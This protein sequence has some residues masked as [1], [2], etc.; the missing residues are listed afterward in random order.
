[1]EKEE[2]QSHPEVSSCENTIGLSRII[3]R[4]LIKTL[5]NEHGVM[6]QAK[7]PTVLSLRKKEAD[8]ICQDYM[9]VQP[10]FLKINLIVSQGFNLEYHSNQRLIFPLA[11]FFYIHTVHMIKPCLPSPLFCGPIILVSSRLRL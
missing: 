10:V 1:M 2:R 7:I 8:T 4:V 6:A 5:H 11:L 9:Y 3:T